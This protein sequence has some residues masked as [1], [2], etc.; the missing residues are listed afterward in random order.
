MQGRIFSGFFLCSIFIVVAGD[1]Q[2][3]DTTEKPVWTMEFIKVKPDNFGSTMGYLDDHWMRLRAEAKRQ[4]AV[5]DYH[6]IQNGTL[7][8][9]SHKVSDPHSIVLL[10]EYKDMDAFMES[11]KLFASIREHR[12][13]GFETGGVMRMRSSP[14]DLFETLNTQVFLEEPDTNAT[15]KPLAKQ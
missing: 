11:E 9:P 10:T 5:L 7:L 6:R 2:R 15:L 14:E 1:A 13:K 12:P 3:P 8:T 4:G